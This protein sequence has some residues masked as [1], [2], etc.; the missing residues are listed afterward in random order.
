ML[1]VFH[2]FKGVFRESW[3]HGLGA[4]GWAWRAGCPRMGHAG[5]EWLRRVASLRSVDEGV[6]IL[7]LA[8][9]SRPLGERGAVSL[10]R[11]REH[12]DKGGVR[13]WVL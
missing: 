3:G 2:V 12:S 8:P 4:R 10:G 9:S 5:G 11:S 1:Q 6:L 7:I 13:V